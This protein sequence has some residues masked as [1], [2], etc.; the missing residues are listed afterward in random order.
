MSVDARPRRRVHRVAVEADLVTWARD[1][2]ELAFAEL[3]ER[4]RRRLFSVCVRITGDEHSA[5]DAA[6]SALLDAWRALPRFEGRSSFSTWLC[7]IGTRASLALVRRRR[8]DPMAEVPE[9][10]GPF[11]AALEESVSSVSAVR[12]ALEKLPPD[13]RTALVLREYADMS[14]QEIAETL[15]V[16]V[17]TVKTRIARARRAVAHALEAAEG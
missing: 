5:R 2:D 17:E 7:Q 12:W 14:Y 6:Q 16:R 15:D 4:S 9:P 10:R 13:F 3:V 11:S 1:G 8:A